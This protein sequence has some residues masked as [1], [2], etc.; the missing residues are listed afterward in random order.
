MHQSVGVHMSTALQA[1]G[2]KSPLKLTNNSLQLE[3]VL[4]VAPAHAPACRSR[5]PH[6]TPARSTGSRRYAG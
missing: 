3:T 6:F 1:E 5:G 2:G 4:N